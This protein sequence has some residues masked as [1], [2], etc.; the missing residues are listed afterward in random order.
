MVLVSLIGCLLNTGNVSATKLNEKEQT[1]KDKVYE[2][3]HEQSFLGS[4][5]TP[6]KF[7]D[8]CRYE[9]K[10]CLNNSGNRD[11]G[12]QYECTTYQTP[13]EMCYSPNNCD[14]IYIEYE[15]C[16]AV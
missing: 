16:I 2:Y 1:C 7:Y 5:P 4:K 9:L 12:T 8:C 13:T 11:I 3:C 14:I 15:E 6:P 10:A